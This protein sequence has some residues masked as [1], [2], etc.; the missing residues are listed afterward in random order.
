MA[1][2]EKKLARVSRELTARED[3]GEAME[4]NLHRLVIDRPV[5]LHASL[6]QV[7]EETRDAALRSQGISPE[8]DKVIHAVCDCLTDLCDTN[9]LVAAKETYEELMEIGSSESVS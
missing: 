6:R 2:F 8:L 5:H 4:A 3:S 9:S 7:L 1:N